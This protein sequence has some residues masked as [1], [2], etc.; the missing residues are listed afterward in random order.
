MMKRDRP[1]KETTRILWSPEYE[2]FLCEKCGRAMEYNFSFR[3]CPY[4]GRKV[5]TNE[6][7]GTIIPSMVMPWR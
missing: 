2:A 5:L 7:R 4:C 1:G 6:R 3:H